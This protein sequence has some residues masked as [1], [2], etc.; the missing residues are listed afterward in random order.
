MELITCSR[1]SDGINKKSHHLLANL[2]AA[3]K[4]KINSYAAFQIFV[5]VVGFPL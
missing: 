3:Q 4:L 2:A 1:V 5:I